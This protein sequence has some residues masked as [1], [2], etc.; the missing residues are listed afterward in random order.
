MGNDNN[1][2]DN[3]ESNDNDVVVVSENDS[4]TPNNIFEVKGSVLLGW[5]LEPQPVGI[6]TMK[7]S[8]NFFNDD[9]EDDEDDD[10]DA[11]DEDRWES[12]FNQGDDDDGRCFDE[13]DGAFQ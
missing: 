2:K 5:G 12:L 1:N 3:D 9:V 11:R 8:V 4:K 13:N 6:F 10:D 7:E